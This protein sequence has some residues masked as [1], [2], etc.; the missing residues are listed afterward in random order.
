[1]THLLL[2]MT[3]ALSVL[4]AVVDISHRYWGRVALWVAVGLCCLW[5]IVGTA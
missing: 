2:S 1:M 3:L 4:Y 5:R